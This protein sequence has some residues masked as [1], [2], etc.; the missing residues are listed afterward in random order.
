MKR[1]QDKVII[2]TGASSGLGA[3]TARQLGAEGAKVVLAARRRDKGEKVLHEIEAAGGEGIFVQTDVNSTTDIKAL[4]AAAT[5]RFGGLDGAFNNAGITGPTLMPLADIEEADWDEALTT[6]LRAVFVC[7]K[8]QIPALLA[9]G[10]GA[11]VNMASMYGLKAGDLGNSPYCASKFGV[12]GLSKT[13]AID[14]ADKGVRVN[15]ICPGFIHS[16]MVDPYIEA[17]PDLMARTILRHSAMN[18]VGESDEIAQAVTWLLS[19]QASFVNG[20]ALLVSG[21]ETSR[22]Y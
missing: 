10:G 6:N 19:A 13:A 16:E 20:T 1:M 7:M 18:R 5:A 11:I 12:V 9:R 22:L 8:Y 15:A 3:A 2:V 14:Y 17:E 4:I 21:G